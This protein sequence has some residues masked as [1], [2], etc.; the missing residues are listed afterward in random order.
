M[1]LDTGS[2]TITLLSETA[3]LAGLWLTLLGDP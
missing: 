2:D 1:T 3:T